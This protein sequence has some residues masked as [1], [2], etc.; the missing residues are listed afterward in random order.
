MLK[1]KKLVP[2]AKL[3]F[4]V[5]PGD[6]GMD[7]CS[8]VH[9]RVCFGMV[10]FVRTGLAVEIPEGFELQVRPRSGLARRG[11][12]VVNSPGTIDSG[13]R[14]EIC[15]ILT[16]VR[17]PEDLLEEGLAPTCPIEPGDRIAQLVLAKVERLPVVEVQ[18][19]SETERGQSGF[20][21][22]GVK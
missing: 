1:F 8:I 9:G 16:S 12:T 21:S 15:V 7:I 6:A 17:T 22:T 19:L 18:E 4:Y 5:N 3:P 13:F 11:V 10:T 2:E 14:G 20:G